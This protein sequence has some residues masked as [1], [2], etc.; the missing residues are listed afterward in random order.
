MKTAKYFQFELDLIKKGDIWHIF[1]VYTG[2]VWQ[3]PKMLNY[4][5]YACSRVT[6]YR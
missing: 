4:S 1:F 6:V 3:F 5:F 2:M